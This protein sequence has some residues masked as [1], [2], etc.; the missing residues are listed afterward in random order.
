MRDEAVRFRDLQ[1]LPT[2]NSAR[3]VG[4]GAGLDTVVREVEIVEPEAVMTAELPPAALI[5]LPFGDTDGPIHQEHLLD[6]MLRRAH[7]AKVCA[8]IVTGHHSEIATATRRL[9]DKFAI[10]TL[11]APDRLPA[12]P[13]A[14]HLRTVVHEPRV[15]RSRILHALTSRLR[16]HGEKLDQIVTCLAT[17]LDAAATACT[18]QGAVLSGGEPATPVPDIVSS[19]TLCSFK[20]GDTSIAVLP[21]SGLA[22]S[23]ALWVAVERAGAGALWRGTAELCLSVAHGPLLA[24]LA[25]E[26]LTAERDARLRGTLLAE[27]LEHGGAVTSA[28]AE[29]AAMAGWE[30]AGWHV[31]LHFRLSHSAGLSTFTVDTLARELAA[32]QLFPG[33]LVERADGWST[34]ITSPQAV[35]ADHAH[36]VAGKLTRALK[37]FR[38]RRSGVTV[39]AGVGSPQRDASGIATT[40]AEARQAAVIAASSGDGMAVRVVQDLGASRLLLGWYS[41]SAFR[42]YAGQ[43]LRPLLD[44][45][46]KDLIATLEAYLD[47][48]CSAMQTGRVLGI[49][50]N[51]VSQRMAR[52]E[53]LLGLS[54]SQADTRLA[55]QLALRALRTSDLPTRTR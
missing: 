39:A 55:V 34:W 43:I 33:P 19:R 18:A 45:R 52:A 35:P 10:P 21:V 3:L 27:I 49:H 48:S 9:A 11:V 23:A 12:L 24:W 50:R 40:L 5:V 8:I 28:V 54:L 13:L 1:A 51:T 20:T 38:D 16:T 17:T 32:A 15:E 29:Q 37:A 26:Q 36:K 2:L 7:L 30:L 53:K 4:G 41:S 22:G 47:R 14:V 25:R 46:D 31:G 6:L 44:T 42:D